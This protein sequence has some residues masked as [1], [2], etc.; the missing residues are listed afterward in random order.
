M[1]KRLLSIVLTTTI[2]LSAFTAFPV[3]VN[4][5]EATEPTDSAE[6]YSPAEDDSTTFIPTEPS[7]ELE[8]LEETEPNIEQ[9]S[10]ALI[11]T[12]VPTENDEDSYNTVEI[13]SKPELASTGANV[14]TY[15]QVARYVPNYVITDS[16]TIQPLYNPYT[17]QMLLDLSL[18]AYQVID[19]NY[20]EGWQ[21]TLTDL[22]FTTRIATAG[23]TTY[24]V[25]E[26]SNGDGVPSTP[27]T[28]GNFHAIIGLKRVMYND[29]EKYTLVIAFRGTKSIQDLIGTDFNFL[30]TAEGFH[31]GFRNCSKDFLYYFKNTSFSIKGET[32]TGEDILNSMKTEN[33]KY[34][35][36]VTG[37]SLGGA[38]ADVFVG[39]DLY[40]MGIHPSNVIAYTFAAPT[41][42][43]SY[44]S[45]PYK[46][47]I[48][49]INEDD[50]VPTVGASKRIGT[51]FRYTPDDTFRQTHYKNHYEEGHGTAWW[52][53]I[54][55]E[56]FHFV[57]HDLDRVYNPIIDYIQNHIGDYTSYHT[58]GDN[59][60][61]DNIT[62]TK[63]S[64]SK[65]N[66]SLNCKQALYVTVN[67]NLTITGQFSCYRLFFEGGNLIVDGSCSATYTVIN[68]INNIILNDIVITETL[69]VNDGSLTVKGDLTVG[70]LH[71]NNENGYLLAERDFIINKGEP[72]DNWGDYNNRLTAG[73]LELKGDFYQYSYQ[74]PS[75]VGAA[76]VYNE[77]G[78]HKTIFSG[79]KIQR[80]SFE[81]NQS[82]MLNN[83]VFINNDVIIDCKAGKIR[84]CED[85]YLSN[86]AIL[87]IYKLY[88]NG[89][90]LHKKGDL[91][92]NY[93]YTENGSLTVDGSLSGDKL[94]ASSG[95]VSSTQ[96]T[97][98]STV[99][100]ESQ[101][102]NVFSTDFIVTETLTV[103]D[104]SLTAK[105]DLTVGR[106]HMNNE[107]GYLLAERD[108]I[109]NKGE[110]SDNWGDYNNRLTAGTLELKGDFYQYSYQYPSGVGAAT[111]YNETG[112]HKTI[113]SGSK[114][115]RVSFEANQSLML[116]N[117]VF[118]NNDVIIDCKAGK[119][120]LC[121][122]TYL[123]NEA[124]LDIYKLYLNGYS[125]HKKG[126]LYANYLYTENGSLTVDGSLSGDKLEASSGTVSST[127]TTTFS[128]VSV[129]SQSHNVFSTDFIVTETLTVKDGSLT[130]K[131]DLTVGRLHMNNENGYLLAEKDLIINKGEPND[132]WGDYNHQLS[133][134]TLELKGDFYQYS[135]QY[136]SGVG[137]ATY[138]NET[139]SHKT[140][141]SG[142]RTQHITFETQSIRFCTIILNNTYGD[143]VFNNRIT[144]SNLFD[145]KG[146]G[147]ELFEN[148]VGSTFVDYDGDGLKD[149]VDPYPTDPNNMSPTQEPTQPP[150]QNPTQPST[151]EPTQTPTQEPT[152]TPTQESSNSPTLLGDV[153]GDGTVTIIDA[154][155]IQRHL[156]SIPSS[157]A[158]I[159]ALADT[160]GDGGTTI[161]DAT[162]IQ[163]WLANLP[164]NNNIG[165]PIE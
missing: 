26:I 110:P 44:Y 49:I 132:Y 43:P 109:I 93:L 111:V 158:F 28:L 24:A 159:E 22:G 125:L 96:T 140:V 137:A 152:Q 2:I 83:P 74:Y 95:T 17:A 103:K 82:L 36:L 165:K 16:N 84:L 69:T 8:S 60:W 81:A 130:A 100:V 70:R 105:G 14:E 104:G 120:R 154:T 65:I 126:D 32:I 85:T 91:Y 6:T 98:F 143:V 57:S 162:F 10:A 67:S 19:P 23:S 53:N 33:S 78:T 99:S 163:R 86:E 12:E 80:V 155:C 11:A 118:I 87:D 151:Q 108:F 149:H 25:G 20:S 72:S 3:S 64:F 123:S 128:T 160:D 156:A 164:T 29:Q 144:V 92:A 73:T 38:M 40:E 131:G 121:E 139:A 142:S 56:A 146:N 9:P 147:F 30:P 89:Y 18:D 77:T 47:I 153:D 61:L 145:H 1:L 66:G 5:E 133:A 129:E 35:V 112:T 90:S 124:I 101:S 54:V 150:T 50:F 48:N 122:D 21:R 42:A 134:G 63:D 27:I 75:G 88:L 39:Y 46:N 15:E 106:L 62:I 114:I 116:N 107:N 127:Q 58:N 7:T 13:Q 115:Q 113:F 117:P 79:S 135:Y 94:E 51:D 41:S 31:S 119:I 141:F 34:S 136:P 37:H 76:T 148:G 71:M 161:I 138:Y 102:H 52:S 157:F 4:A 45:Y 97:T 59:T 68:Y 55:N